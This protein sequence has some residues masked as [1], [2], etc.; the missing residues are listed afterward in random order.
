MKWIIYQ[1]NTHCDIAGYKQKCYLDSCETIFK[2]RFWN[3][4][5][6]WN[7]FKHKNHTELSIEFS[8]IKKCNGTPKITWK[9]I[10]ICLLTIQTVN[11]A[12][13]V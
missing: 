4:K 3:H 6:P 2:D 1:A 13:Y 9:I 10:T 7:H 8:E 11:A 12:F 5:K